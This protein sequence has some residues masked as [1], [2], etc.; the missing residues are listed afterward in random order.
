M[1][2]VEKISKI[3]FNPKGILTIIL[4]HFADNSYMIT[5]IAFRRLPIL[6]ALGFFASAAFAQI[7]EADSL[8]IPTFEFSLVLPKG[9]KHFRQDWS[10]SLSFPVRRD[11]SSVTNSAGFELSEFVIR[12]QT[13]VLSGNA[14]CVRLPRYSL[15]D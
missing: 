6:L 13:E 4:L 3:S 10:N 5:K 7:S 9:L 2:I 1:S 8:E 15:L 14:R 12:C 11:P